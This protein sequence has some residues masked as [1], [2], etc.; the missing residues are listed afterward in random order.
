M[1]WLT[2]TLLGLTTLMLVTSYHLP[3]YKIL[4]PVQK[5]IPPSNFPTFQRT[6]VE[7]R[8]RPS[9]LISNDVSI[10]PEFGSMRLP[11]REAVESSPRVTFRFGALHD[12]T[13]F[14]SL[15]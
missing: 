7:G 12:D 15:P 4:P 5:H 8:P 2:V 10:D 6:S 1:G 11:L 3:D 13:N 14:I 9:V